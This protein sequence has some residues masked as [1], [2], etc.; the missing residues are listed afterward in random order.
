MHKIAPIPPAIV[1]CVMAKHGADYAFDPI[2]LKTT[3]LIAI[4]M[5]DC[6][7]TE[8]IA[9]VFVPHATDIIPNIIVWRNYS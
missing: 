6:F 7:L 2:N 8:S 5:Q 1:K 9:S 4:D 3:A